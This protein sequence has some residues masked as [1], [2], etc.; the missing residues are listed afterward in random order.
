MG[1]EAISRGAISATL[2]EKDRQAA[3]II[4]KNMAAL[5]LS[6]EIELISSEALLA[7]KKIKISFDIIYLD[8]PYELP[9][10]PFVQEIIQYKLLAPLG[11]LF[12]EESSTKK[13]I[14]APSFSSLTLISSRRVGSALLHQYEALHALL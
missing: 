4:R 2:V 7:L 10:A 8:P 3:S 9:C 5:H 14:R 13:A 6:T 12:I 11:T 1:I